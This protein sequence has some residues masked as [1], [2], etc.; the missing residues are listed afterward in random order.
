MGS[1]M[2]WPSPSPA[3]QEGYIQEVGRHPLRHLQRLRPG[4][5]AYLD[6][7][8]VDGAPD[9]CLDFSPHGDE[10]LDRPPP[11]RSPVWAAEGPHP[12]WTGPGSAFPAPTLGRCIRAI[13][14]GKITAFPARCALSQARCTCCRP[15]CRELLR[16]HA[17]GFYGSGKAA[18]LKNQNGYQVAEEASF[19]GGWQGVPFNP[20]REG[21]HRHAGG[22]MGASFW[23]GRTPSPWSMDAR[24]CRAAGQPLPV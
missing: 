6:D 16:S 17:A 13:T 9:Y 19:P 4:I 8:Y 24:V 23:S 12:I 15:G 1:G 7:L 2:S 3:G 21:K 18:L 10:L 22:W 11:G 14:C 20:L 5:C